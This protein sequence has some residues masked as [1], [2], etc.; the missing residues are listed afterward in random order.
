M[1]SSRRTTVSGSCAQDQI[2]WDT[3]HAQT[4]FC[5]PLPPVAARSGRN[6]LVEA[7]PM[8]SCEASALRQDVLVNSVEAH[9]VRLLS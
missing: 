9:R 7:C 2:F 6:R 4:L 1:N 5:G 8:E 3:G